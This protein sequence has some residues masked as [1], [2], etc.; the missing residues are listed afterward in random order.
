MFTAPGFEALAAAFD[1]QL[2]RGLHSG[3]QLSVRLGGEPVLDRW[4][5]AAGPEGSRAGRRP[6]GPT[7]P[8]M[9]YSSTKALTAACVHKLAEE[10][11]LELASPVAPYWPAF[12]HRGKGGITIEHLLLHQAGIPA[13]PGLADAAAWLLPRGG[14]LRAAAMAPA[15]APGGKCAYHA[16]SAGFVLGE[17][18]RRASGLPCGRYLEESF[19]APLGMADSSAGLPVT[20]Y[21]TASRIATSDPA[22]AAAAALFSNPV[23]RSLFVPAASL[24]TT[25]RDLCVFYAMLGSGGEWEGRRY[26]GRGAVAR[27]TALAY[28]GPDGDTGRRIRWARG[29]TVGGYS[30]FPDEDIRMMGRASTALTFG[31]SG[32]GGCSIGWAD[33]PTGLSFAFVCNTFLDAKS[34]H[35][36]FE[37]L[38][39]AAFS[40]LAGASA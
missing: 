6:I 11:R 23:Y 13:E 12:G 36:R 8:F 17:L 27:A 26:L 35:R 25:A 33:P 37:E 14:A 40:C 15:W 1:G 39:D 9:A 5:G 38:A 19:L 32:Q 7:T 21:A 31:H 20:R 34:S 18:V 30:T 2:A 16:F 4:G 29:F 28:D 10:G 22:Q 24:N 3:A